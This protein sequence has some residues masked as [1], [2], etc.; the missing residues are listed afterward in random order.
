MDGESWIL[1]N[2]SPDLRYQIESFPPLQPRSSA[3]RSSPIAAIVIPSAEV[4][5]ALG[6]LLLREFQPLTVY[7]TSAVRRIL[8]EDNS[9]FGVLRRIPNQVTWVDIVPNE[10]FLIGDTGIRCTPVTTESGFPGFVSPERASQF[11][12]EEAVLGLY[13]EHAGNRVAFFPGVSHV[14][15]AWVEQFETC[16]AVF[17]DGTFWSEDELIRVHGSGKRA[18]DMGHQPVSETIRCLQDLN[19]RKIFIHINNTNP[20]LDEAGPEHKAVREAGWDIAYDGMHLKL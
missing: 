3:V 16:D 4:D 12:P 15:P 9:L 20:M 14:L 8:T 19:T 5:A 10:A 17:F 13:V 2:A 7:A 11:P 18:S 1:L 6:L